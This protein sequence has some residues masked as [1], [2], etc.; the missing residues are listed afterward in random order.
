VQRGAIAGDVWGGAASTL[1]ALPASIAFGVAV[2]APLGGGAG[3]GALAGL[4]GATALGTIAPLLGGTPRLVS[5]PC[6]PAVAVMG[7]FAIQTAAARPGDPARVVVL[8]TLVGLVAALL[9]IALGLGRAGTIIKYIPYPVVTGYMSGVGIVIFLKQLPPLLGYAKGT[10][11]LAGVTTPALWQWPSL[12]VGAV[13]IAGMVL[14]SRVTRAVPAAIVGLA[15]GLV[16]YFALALFLPE[17]RTLTDNAMVIGPLDSAGASFGDALRTR[18][19]SL[20]TL[21]WSDVRL[22]IGPALTLAVV[23]SLDTLKTCVV[24]DAMT[25]SQHDSNRELFGQGV[26]NAVAAAIGGIPGAGT[27]GAT[28]VNVASGARTRWSAVIEGGLVLLAFLTLGGVV[29][30]A[31]LAALAGILV[32]VAVR[33][34]DW[35]AL[36]WVRRTTTVLDFIVVVAVV[37]VAVGVD[38]ITAS[39]V[40]VALS[41]L[42]FIRAESRNA[43]IRRKLDGSQVF[44]KRRRQPAEL[45]VLV[46]HGTETVVVQLAG[47]LFFGTTDQLRRQLKEDLETRRTI[48]FDLRRVDALDL[49]AAHI[50]E[51]MLSKLDRRGASAVFCNLPRR[52]AGQHDVPR[53]LREVGLIED[54]R[55]PIVFANLSDALAWAEDRTLREHAFADTSNEGPLEL[56]QMPIFAGRKPETVADM[57]ACVEQRRVMA[58]AS[59]FRQGDVSDEMYFVRAGTVRISLSLEARHLHVASFGRGDFFGELAF[60]DGGARSADAIAET[61]VELYVVSRER[62]DAVAA[63]HPRL[64]QALF[65]SIAHTLAFRLRIADA[66][67]TTLEEA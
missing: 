56:E 51:Q 64:A 49:T 33:M 39:G 7:A 23:L 17:L 63:A 53:Y 13:T 54:A 59:V 42:L 41:I 14:A 5:A 47:S 67:I 16:C 61:D 43:V 10:P 57:M 3:A 34:F 66:E 37:G 15:L 55:E 50:L 35:K 28:L 46:Q 65:A 1:V 38:L 8:M 29:G 22:V 48:V 44:S 25:G 21:A 40:G 52:L 9:Q 11:L 27:S 4:L 31:P 24:V 18:F 36:R 60:L 6:A 30:W 26:A 32:V 45:A 2:H 58:G 19:T 62:F 20:G 12:A